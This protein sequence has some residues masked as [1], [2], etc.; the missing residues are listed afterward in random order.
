MCF[1][2]HCKKG[3]S[4]CLTKGREQDRKGNRGGGVLLERSTD[5]ASLEWLRRAVVVSHAAFSCTLGGEEQGAEF[6]HL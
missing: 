2:T 3:N 1:G 5:S 6:G 4:G